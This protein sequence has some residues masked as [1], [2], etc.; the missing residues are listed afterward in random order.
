MKYSIRKYGDD[1]LRK[2]T[3]Q[4]ARVDDEV[5]ELA[6]NMIETMHAE[7]GVGLAAPQVGRD[8]ALCVIH[9]PQPYDTDE[10]GRRF[11]PGV[12][13]PLVLV[14][15]Q[16]TMLSRA[17]ET[18]EEGCL[19][20]PDIS[21]LVPRAR[22]ITVKFLDLEGREQVVTACNFL[23]RAIQHEVDHLNGVLLV[24]R[25]SPV[26]RIALAG[27]LKR[28]KRETQEELALSRPA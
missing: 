7:S 8:V 1:V 20:F 21:A 26:K 5:R 14:N 17:T 22:E 23:A 24:D 3:Q 18:I 9:I 10:N 15:P 25:M 6:R 27:R 19:S 11:N 4:V 12:A 13:M 28:L 2:S 16:I